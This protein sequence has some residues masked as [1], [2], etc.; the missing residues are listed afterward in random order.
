M[1]CAGN[2]RAAHFGMISVGDWA[3]VAISEILSRAKAKSSATQVLISGFRSL[4]H[5]IPSLPR[6]RELDLPLAELAKSGAFLAT[7]LN[8]VQ[9]TRD[10][11]APIRLGHSELVWLCL[12]QGGSNQI[13]FLDDSGRIV[14]LKC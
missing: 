10:H 13:S 3:G 4:R 11:G 6:P 7:Q 14:P 12:H 9:L 2:T 8:S 5:Q 1:E